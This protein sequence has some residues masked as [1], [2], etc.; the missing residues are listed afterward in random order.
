[1]VDL[2]TGAVVLDLAHEGYHPDTVPFSFAFATAPDGRPL[3]IHRTAWNRLDIWDLRAGRCLT[4]R[5][6][7]CDRDPKLRSHCL[8]YFHGRLLVGPDGKRLLDAGWVWQ[9]LCLPLVWNLEAWLANPF[10]SEDGPTCRDLY[11]QEAW[12]VGM[13]FL[14]PDRVA[15]GGMVEGAKVPQGARVYDLADD[16]NPTIPIAIPGPQGEFFSDGNVLYSSGP[17]GL[18]RWDLEDGC[19]TGHIPGFEPTRH[20]RGAG[21]LA[22]LKDGVLLRWQMPR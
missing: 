20:H 11:Q 10:E 13:A 6:C 3:A 7:V 2:A 18:S 16:P 12:N 1:M 14:G 9:P 8:D 4:E 17:G 15:I 22:Q 21:E 5:E 19:R